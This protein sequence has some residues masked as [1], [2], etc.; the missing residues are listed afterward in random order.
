MC[1]LGQ[2]SAQLSSLWLYIICDIIFSKC[3]EGYFRSFIPLA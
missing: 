3:V 1:M 2:V